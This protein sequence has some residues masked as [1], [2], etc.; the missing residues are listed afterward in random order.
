MNLLD[1]VIGLRR[2]LVRAANASFGDPLSSRHAAI[3]RE[4]RASGPTSQ[5]SLARATA[6]DPSLVVRVLD[7]LEGQKL[8]KRSRNENDRRAMVVSLT[9]EG[10]QAL[11]PLDAAYRRLAGAMQRPLSVDERETF[12]ALA[13]KITESLDSASARAAESAE[14]QH[15]SR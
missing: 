8:V 13:H 11:G 15:A 1:A 5:I 4:L 7:D 9:D 2:A 3:L 6:V 12:I 14:Y 10:R